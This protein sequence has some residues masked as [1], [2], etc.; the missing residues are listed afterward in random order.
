[1]HQL[2]R[3]TGLIFK[4]FLYQ[5]VMSLFGFMMYSSTY[6]IPFL[7]VIGQATVT[8][9]FLFIMAHQTYQSGAKA[10][11][12]DWAHDLSSSP[13]FGLIFSLLAFLPTI[14]L[15]TYTLIYP[16][17]ATTGTPSTGYAP[18]LINKTFLQGMYIGIVQFLHPT[19][20]SASPDALAHANNAQ[21]FVH[22]L[23]CI[24]GIISC[25]FGYFVG[26]CNFKKEKNH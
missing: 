2:K 24:P 21:C 7:M 6:K 19:S 18:F 16:P 12:F 25:T 5:V 9:F 23:S 20:A 17:F 10:C 22:L 15:S 11:E 8:L 26:Y 14:L 4:T 3:N 1:M 13:L